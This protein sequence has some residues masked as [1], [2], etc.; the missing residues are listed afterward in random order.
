MYVLLGLVALGA[1]LELVALAIFVPVLTGGEAS[2]RI[3]D[4]FR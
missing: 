3:R 4:A 1:L 2:G